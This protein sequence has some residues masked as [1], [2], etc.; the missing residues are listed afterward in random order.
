MEIIEEMIN[1]V[2]VLKLKGRLDAATTKYVK[3]K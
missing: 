2:V 3:E 1:D